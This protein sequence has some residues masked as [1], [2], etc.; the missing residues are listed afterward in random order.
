[1]TEAAIELAVAALERSGSCHLDP[2]TSLPDVRRIVNKAACD[3]HSAT[4][5]GAS[6]RTVQLTARRVRNLPA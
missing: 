4:L 3:W 2:G 6:D 5:S 1:L